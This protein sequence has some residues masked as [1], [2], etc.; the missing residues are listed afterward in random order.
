MAPPQDGRDR[1]L[2]RM[3]ELGVDVSRETSDQLDALVTTLIPW[4]KA[5]N[6]VGKTTIEGVWTRHVLD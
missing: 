4:Q 5:I 2:R 6:L 1:F 3:R